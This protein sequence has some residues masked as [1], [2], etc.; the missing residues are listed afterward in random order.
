MVPIPT[1]KLGGGD[2]RP[3]EGSGRA[4]SGRFDHQLRR[5]DAGAGREQRADVNEHNGFSWFP[6]RA[7]PTCSGIRLD[8]VQ[9]HGRVDAMRSEM[10]R[11]LTQSPRRISR[12]TGDHWGFCM[13][14]S[15]ARPSKTLARVPAASG[16]ASIAMPPSAVVRTFKLANNCPTSTGVPLATPSMP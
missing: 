4:G 5:T 1:A 16:G 15:R 13:R 3:S 8:A 7:R 12:W 10:R 6:L 9:V 11:L 2:S 14:S